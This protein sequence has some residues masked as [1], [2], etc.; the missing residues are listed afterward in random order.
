[1]LWRLRL[2]CAAIAALLPISATAT[3]APPPASDGW[4][5]AAPESV[6]IDADRLCALVPWVEGWKEGDIHAVLVARHAKLVFEQYFSGADEHW[7]TPLG[8]DTAHSRDQ[9]HDAR[10]VT[11]S[12]VAL[13]LGIAL[14]RGLIKGG[15]DT[16]VLDL[17]PQYADLRTPEKVKITF[18][19]V[20]YPATG[21]PVA[22]S[23]LR[24]LPRDFAKIG[25]L[26]HCATC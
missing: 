10:S 6:G 21:E 25:Q 16:P 23:G 24:L 26:V 22:A 19:W 14:D 7:G 13:V 2:L 12:V 8:N 11:K 3:C 15:L 1:M 17:L 4:A 20:R 5:V 9:L 18:E